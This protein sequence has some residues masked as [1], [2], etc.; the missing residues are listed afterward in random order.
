MSD[1]ASTTPGADRLQEGIYFRPGKRPGRCYR[2]L[3]LN[4]AANTTLGQLKEGIRTIWTKL[5]TLDDELSADLRPDRLWAPSK[6]PLP[7]PPALTCLLGI[8]A[9]LFD[10]Y[11]SLERPTQLERL[12]DDA[13]FPSLPSVAKADVQSGEAHFVLQFIAESE[14]AVSRAVAETWLLI[15]A[16][17]LRFE[18]TGLYAGFNREDRR[19]WLGFHDGINNIESK[20][21]RG[22]IEA[23]ADAATGENPAWMDGGTYMGYLRLALDLEMWNALSPQKQEH[24]VGRRK[25]N[26]CPILHIPRKGEDVGLSGC[27]KT[28]GPDSEEY[29]DPPPA[30]R[31]LDDLAQ[32]THVNRANVNRHHDFIAADDRDNRIFRQSYEFLEALPDGRIRI[33]VNFVSFQRS[34]TCLTAILRNLGWLGDANFGDEKPQRRPLVSLIGGGL[35]AVPPMEQPFPGATVF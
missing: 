19:S 11:P 16:K 35:Y 25:T 5:H 4:A 7:P 13:P 27:P 22:A 20:L 23:R 29:R 26:G 10:A 6:A 12:E 1:S 33:G 3:L 2:L 18:V 17:R 8:G 32:F 21:R 28:V 31:N 24:I 9:A 15:R 34:L 30:S 14:L